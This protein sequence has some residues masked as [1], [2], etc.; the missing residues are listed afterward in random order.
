MT[1]VDRRPVMLSELEMVT[2]IKESRRDNQLEVAFGGKLLSVPGNAWAFKRVE[3]MRGINLE[4][5]G[6]ERV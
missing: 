2:L 3:E 6:Y 1:L 4:E 5:V